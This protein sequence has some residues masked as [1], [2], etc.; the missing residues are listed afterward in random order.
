[1]A[2]LGQMECPGTPGL[3]QAPGQLLQIIKNGKA[4]QVQFKL[5]LS[6]G[7]TQ[8]VKPPN[9]ANLKRS[10]RQKF[11]KKNQLIWPCGLG[12][13]HGQSLVKIHFLNN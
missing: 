12:V 7:P 10:S 2:C 1:M 3:L 11:S 5:S 13:I 6:S 9:F 8:G 4:N